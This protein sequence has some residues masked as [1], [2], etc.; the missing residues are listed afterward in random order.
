[1]LWPLAF[2]IGCL[3]HRSQTCAKLDKTL[4][5]STIAKILQFRT[6]STR[7]SIREKN[8]FNFYLSLRLSLFF[9][10]SFAVLPQFSGA[11]DVYLLLIIIICI[12][13]ILQP[14][15]QCARFRMVDKFCIFQHF[16]SL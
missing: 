11:I 8:L 12:F 3:Y 6:I 14:H 2:Q 4:F 1:M 7:V 16:T 10:F 9:F 13:F 15:N 5:C